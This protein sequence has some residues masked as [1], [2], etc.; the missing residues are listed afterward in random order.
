MAH[1]KQKLQNYEIEVAGKVHPISDPKVT[2]KQIVDL[3]NPEPITPGADKREM[4]I[5][6]SNAASTPK[7]G[8]WHSYDRNPVKASK[9]NLT[10]F[11]VVI[12]DIFVWT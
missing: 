8:K 4:Y 12:K 1:S 5:V 6:Y 9:T 2:F 7:K 10:K 11:N 3:A